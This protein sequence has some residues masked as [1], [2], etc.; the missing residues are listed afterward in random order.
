MVISVVPNN[1]VYWH[2][3]GA[4]GRTNETGH[5]AIRK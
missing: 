1:V 2:I 3:R 5:A 4:F